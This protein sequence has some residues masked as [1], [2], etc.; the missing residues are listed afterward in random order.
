MPARYVGCRHRGVAADAEG[1]IAA[2]RDSKCEKRPFR[3]AFAGF[4][5]ISCWGARNTC[6]LRLVESASHAKGGQF[7]THVKALPGNP[8][9][10]HTLAT[11][12]PDMEALVGNTIERILADKGYRGHNALPDSVVAPS[13][14]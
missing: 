1:L 13:P 4:A 10:G 12:I 11:V 3:I 7:V 2:K 14:R 5:R 9:D 6:F 8:Y